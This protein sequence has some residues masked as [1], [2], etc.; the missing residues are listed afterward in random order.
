MSQHYEIKHATVHERSL[1]HLVTN[2]IWMWSVFNEEKVLNFNGYLV[3]TGENQSVIID[4]VCDELDPIAVLNAFQPLPKP[5]AI[6]LTNRDHERASRQFKER[7]NIPVI[8]SE[9]DGAL[10]EG[11][12]DRHFRHEEELEGGWRVIELCEQKSPGEVAF[13]EPQRRLLLVG[14]ALI[15]KPT[16]R[17]SMLPADKYADI[18]AARQGLQC[19]GELEVEAVLPC[20][21]D[22]VFFDAQSLLRDAIRLDAP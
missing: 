9:S 18:R 12:P 13:Y 5:T 4:P 20:D 2:G 14:D 16:G 17:L 19:L 3:K 7:F 15:G 11:R 6:W 8:A 21:G 1:P 10:M 22:P